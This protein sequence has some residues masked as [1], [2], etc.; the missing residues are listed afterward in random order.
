MT[1]TSP[2][3]DVEAARQVLI[4]LIAAHGQDRSTGALPAGRF[5]ER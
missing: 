1:Y 2:V 5:Q 3:G 4:D